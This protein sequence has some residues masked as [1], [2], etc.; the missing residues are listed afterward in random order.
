M[1][2]MAEAFAGLLPDFSAF[3]FIDKGISLA[4]KDGVSTKFGGH[5]AAHVAKEEGEDLSLHDMKGSGALDRHSSCLRSVY[6]MEG[7]LRI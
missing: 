5:Y 2:K 1:K 4:V 6:G 3:G 7:L